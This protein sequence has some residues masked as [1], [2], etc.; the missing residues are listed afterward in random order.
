MEEDKINEE[1]RKERGVDEFL[2]T[3]TDVLIYRNGQLVRRTRKYDSPE[4]DDWVPPVY[5]Y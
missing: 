3:Y 5:V 4:V 2:N 1:I